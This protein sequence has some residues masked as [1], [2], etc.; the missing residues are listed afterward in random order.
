MLES[1]VNGS[2]IPCEALF[3][4]IEHTFNSIIDT[5]KMST[6]GSRARMLVWDTTGSPTIGTDPQEIQ[7]CL[8]LLC[9]FNP[10][11]FL[12]VRWLTFVDDQSESYIIAGSTRE[13]QTTYLSQLEGQICFRTCF[14]SAFFPASYVI[15][16]AEQDY[17]TM[18]EGFPSTFR[19]AVGRWLFTEILSS[20]G[21]LSVLQ[22]NIPYIRCL[23][24]S[25]TRRPVD[26]V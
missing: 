15:K 17:Q 2:G 20:N 3:A 25:D 11:D 12:H 5:S 6:S 16:L 23:N 8:F 21:G 10:S 13:E 19:E 1:F 22:T 26:R 9:L 14:R 4:Q 24:H 18:G 7:V